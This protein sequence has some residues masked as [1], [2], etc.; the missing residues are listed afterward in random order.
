MW[1]MPFNAN[2]LFKDRLAFFNCT[3]Y[4]R[5]KRN[6]KHSSNWKGG[7]EISTK[8]NWKS[9]S[10]SKRRR[11]KKFEVCGNSDDF[12]IS[13]QQFGS[14]QI[15]FDAIVLN[16]PFQQK[17]TWKHNT[18]VEKAK[19]KLNAINFRLFTAFQRRIFGWK[20]KHS[21]EKKDLDKLKRFQNTQTH[22]E[23]PKTNFEW[24]IEKNKLTQ[25]KEKK[26]EKNSTLSTFSRRIYGPFSIG[27][28]VQHIL[29]LHFFSLSFHWFH[30]SFGNCWNCMDHSR[31]V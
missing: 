27:F 14:K 9:E 12:S 8:E 1:A 26:M 11:E 29:S 10:N 31:A 13:V 30:K 2:Y 15:L 19:K 4:M 25:E 23:L 21:T 7:K 18:I 28:M 24:T 5:V 16:S 3:M 17:D 6:W 20:P 22:V